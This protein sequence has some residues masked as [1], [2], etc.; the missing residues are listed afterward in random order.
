MGPK[1]TLSHGSTFQHPLPDSKIQNVSRKINYFLIRVFLQRLR[2]LALYGY[3]L[4]IYLL[5]V[6]C[7]FRFG[8]AMVVNFCLRKNRWFG[9][10]PPAATFSTIATMTSTTTTTTNLL[11]NPLNHHH[12]RHHHS[13][14]QKSKK[15]KPKKKQ[16]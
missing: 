10:L 15:L 3:S 12:R 1:L 5:L 6:C 8:L 7:D 4:C 14:Q 2:V 16:D 9:T 11:N 13:H